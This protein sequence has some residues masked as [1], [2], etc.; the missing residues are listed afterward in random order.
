[1]INDQRTYRAFRERSTN[2]QLFKNAVSS[3]LNCYFINF[4]VIDSCSIVNVAIS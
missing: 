1:M 3:I 4:I 2:S